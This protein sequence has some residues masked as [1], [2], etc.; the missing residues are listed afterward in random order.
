MHS[1]NY[2]W[3]EKMKAA[4]YSRK[5]KFTSKGESIDN[6][7]QLCK[8]YITNRLKDKNITEFLIY[9]DEGFSGGNINRPKFQKLLEDA[10]SK[11]FHILICYRLDRI[12]RNVANFSSTLELLQKY[13]IDFIS[14]KEQFDTS[15]PMGRAMI[16]IAS[17]FAQLERETIAER[18]KD[19]MLELSKTGRWLGG[20]SPL[21]YTSKSITF[22]D[23]N[24]KERTMSKL[25]QIP[26]ELETVKHL[27][28][29]YLEFK[30]LT[31]LET[32]MLQNNIKTKRGS[33]FSKS[34]LRIILTNPVYVKSTNEVMEYLQNKGITTCGVPNGSSG[35]L[36]Y[37][38]QKSITND[39]GK[40]V[41]VSRD[42]SEW[43]AAVSI[44]KGIIDADDWL[45]VQQTLAKNKN[46]FPNQGK[47]HNALLTGILKCAE[48]KS[49]MQIAHGHICKKTGKKTYYY[50]CPMKKSSKGLRCH[51]KNVKV[52]ELDSN[53]KT[54]LKKKVFD[55]NKL[56]DNLLEATKK[57]KRNNIPL[58]KVNFLEKSIENKEKEIHN[59][60]NNLAIEK[61]LSHLIINKIKRTKDEII[62]LKEEILK[63]NNSKNETNNLEPDLSFIE[64]FSQGSSIIDTLTIL[65]QKQ[66]IEVLINKITWNSVTHEITI[67]PVN[68]I[69]QK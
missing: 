30:S 3:G 37:N 23:E 43:I 51:N 20:T 52:E 26:S 17:V 69:G 25:K 21:G 14:I 46:K 31:K 10:K 54:F 47:T 39:S 48:C 50:I 9:E 60:L 1:L 7:I 58:N 62:Q 64:I 32:F 8:N 55:K 44:Q 12:S 45:E 28:Q 63:I 41:R 34:N 29:K 68:Q 19:N 67:Y 2:N 5:S 56:L 40:I 27:F 65:E 57:F 22:Y 33:N 11:K 66:L 13:D 24:M 53:I 36:T 49:P 18:I 38:K 59:L 4:I 35:I 16:Y 15:S 42:M 6:Q 61:D